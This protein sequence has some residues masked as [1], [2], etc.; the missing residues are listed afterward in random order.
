MCVCYLQMHSQRE[1]IHPS[2]VAARPDEVSTYEGKQLIL[3]DRFPQRYRSPA[4]W[5]APMAPPSWTHSSGLLSIL[6]LMLFVVGVM[7]GTIIGDERKIEL[8]RNRQGARSAAAVTDMPDLAVARQDGHER[9]SSQVD[10]KEAERLLEDK[11]LELI[12]AKVVEAV[13][14]KLGKGYPP[15]T[16]AS[17]EALKTELAQYRKEVEDLSH[18]TQDLSHY[19]KEIEQSLASI[20][21]G[22][23]TPGVLRNKLNQEQSGAKP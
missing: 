20:D 18:Q 2:F 7:A 9:L 8:A 16:A 19:S 10:V 6:A 22:L 11:K 3:T 14:A 12:A 13:F 4:V 1:R 21:T 15:S 17:A 23:S 5:N